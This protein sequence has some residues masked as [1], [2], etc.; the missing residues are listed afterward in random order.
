VEAGLDLSTGK[1]DTLLRMRGVSS[2]NGTMFSKLAA[3][4]GGSSSF[5]PAN[6]LADPG[7]E[8]LAVF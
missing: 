8:W 2:G 7:K 3:G 1:T 6:S 4:P 5:S